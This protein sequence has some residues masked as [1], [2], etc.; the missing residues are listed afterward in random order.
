MLGLGKIIKK[1]YK[2]SIGNKETSISLRAIV[3]QTYSPTCR[4][5]IPTSLIWGYSV[6]QTV[7]PIQQ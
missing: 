3:L 6:L 7:G 4:V 2:T 1:L 5:D